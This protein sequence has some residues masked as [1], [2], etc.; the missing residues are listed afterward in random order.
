MDASVHDPSRTSHYLGDALYAELIEAYADWQRDELVV[1]DPRVTARFERL[2]YREARLL[3][4]LMYEEWLTCYAPEFVYWVPATADGGD[5]RRE[6][7]VTFDDRRRTEDRIYRFRTG[8]AWSQAPP[9]RTARL[10][11]NV[12]VFTTNRPDV[13]M[14]RSN[15]F[16][17]EFWGETR[18]LTGWTG[19]RFIERNG[20]WL[21]QCKQVNLLECDQPLRNPSIVL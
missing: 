13:M 6:V 16:I 5:A 4:R 11:G 9:S 8:Y 19:H 18:T 2:L 3:D 7:A 20:R 21:I 1:E 17:S 15:F 14:V 10:I 12:E